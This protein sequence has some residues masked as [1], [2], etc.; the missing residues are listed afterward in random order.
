MTIHEIAIQFAH[1]AE[2]NPR[3]RELGRKQD[4]EGLTDEELDEFIALCDA[5][6]DDPFHFL[7][8][9]WE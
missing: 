7:G 4:H 8:D 1:K 5:I 9:D 2:Q 3:L 6:D